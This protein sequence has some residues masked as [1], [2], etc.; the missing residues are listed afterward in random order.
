[1]AFCLCYQQTEMLFKMLY[2]I[3]YGTTLRDNREPF[4]CAR[5]FNTS[6][7]ALFI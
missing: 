4:Y 6:R 2:K 1:M 7:L 3:N 5:G